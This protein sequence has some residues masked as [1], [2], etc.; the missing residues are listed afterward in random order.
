MR[1]IED[2]MKTGRKGGGK[3]PPL[4]KPPSNVMDMVEILQRS[5]RGADAKPQTKS[6]ARGHRKA[7]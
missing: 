6:R 3:R 2:K 5:L 4:P 7:A 1:V